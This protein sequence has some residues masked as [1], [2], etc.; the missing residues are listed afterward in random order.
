MNS[1]IRSFKSVFD[2]KKHHFL[3]QST[4]KND[5]KTNLILIVAQIFELIGLATYKI[6]DSYFNGVRATKYLGEYESEIGKVIDESLVVE[7]EKGPRFIAGTR[8]DVSAKYVAKF[9]DYYWK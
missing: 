4:N 2:K 8:Y 7:T 1:A 3:E 5:L 9:F 6:K